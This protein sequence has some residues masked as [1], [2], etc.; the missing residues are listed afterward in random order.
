MEITSLLDFLKLEL[1][2]KACLDIGP[3]HGESL[4]CMHDHGA[5][6]CAFVERDC[7]FY[8]HNE[9]K[10]Y[11]HGWRLNHLWQLHSLPQ[12]HFDFIWIRGSISSQGRYLY[13][14]KKWAFKL[15]MRQVISLAAPKAVIV[16]SPYWKCPDWLQY[17]LR[18]FQKLPY[19]PGHNSEP[20][21]PVTWIIRPARTPVGVMPRCA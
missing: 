8:R 16:F 20:E 7:W 3:G 15:W 21:Y 2:G 17:E 6:E 11:C 4:D 12:H 1:S 13:F 14:G 9:L 10:P 18:T 19:I 5:A